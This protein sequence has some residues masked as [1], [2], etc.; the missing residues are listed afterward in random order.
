[1]RADS[2]GSSLAEEDAGTGTGGAV[3]TGLTGLSGGGGPGS[4]GT[5]TAQPG[6]DADSAPD[7]DE[8]TTGDG[9]SSGSS[10]LGDTDDVGDTDDSEGESG[11][12][13]TAVDPPEDAV[14]LSGWTVVQTGSDRTFVLPEGTVLPAGA[15]L[16]IG[17]DA[18]RGAFEQYWGALAED[19]VYVDSEDSFPAINGDET[20]AVRDPSDAV[21]DGPTPSLD[22]GQSLTRTDV[23]A[24][25]S[26][27]S[28]GEGDA[29]P[30]VGHA[31]AGT[32]GVFLTEVSDASGSG[33]FVY[34]FIELQ[35]WP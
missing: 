17:R 22:N 21:V 4:D 13:T 8:S 26:W 19:V 14:D 29:D 25:G 18:S 12:S 6:P 15:V 3:T 16:V 33:S 35:A 11:S 9:E 10:G 34:E 20:F 31:F 1:M 23:A 27:T 7:P 30:G 5:T 28:S 24:A 2:E 32:S